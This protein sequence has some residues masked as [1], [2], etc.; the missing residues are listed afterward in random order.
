MILRALPLLRLLPP[1][2]VL[3]FPTKYFTLC[4]EQELTLRTKYSNYVLSMS[5]PSVR[6][7]SYYVLS[8]PCEVLHTMFRRELTQVAGSHFQFEPD[9]NRGENA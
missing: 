9:S 8:P 1:R 4:S 3:I 6:G 7:T 2:E 5:W